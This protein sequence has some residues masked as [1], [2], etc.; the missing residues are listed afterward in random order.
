MELNGLDEEQYNLPNVPEPSV[1]V[2]PRIIFVKEYIDNS[3]LND[4]DSRISSNVSK[5]DR[6]SL[7]PSHLEESV[8][9]SSFHSTISLPSNG[10]IEVENNEQNETEE[11]HSN[12]RNFLDVVNTDNF[13][14]LVVVAICILSFLSMVLIPY[15][16]VILTPFYWYESI[17]IGVLGAIP[18]G[19]GVCVVY[20]RILLEYQD[21]TRPITLLKVF[22]L[23][24]VF[25]ALI[26]VLAHLSWSF[27]LG[28][29]SP[30]PYSLA[31]DVT[32]TSIITVA[33][34]W[35]VLPQNI[36]AKYQ[37]RYKAFIRYILL[38]VAIP[39]VVPM[40][41]E[42]VNEISAV[43]GI[44]LKWMIAVLLLFVKINSNSMMVKVLTIFAL[45][46]KLDLAKNLVTV[47]NGVIFKSI[48][49]ILIGSKTDVV[50]GYC[51]QGISMIMLMRSLNNIIHLHKPKCKCHSTIEAS[52]KR[53]QELLT[54][55]MLNETLDLF[56]TIAYVLCTTVAYYGPN[57]GIIGNIQNNYWQ[58]HIIDS[59]PEFLTTMAYSLL[60]DVSV[61]VI[62]L[63]I[64]WYYCRING[65]LFFK[66]KIGQYAH[67]LVLC[68]TREINLVSI[69][70]IARHCRII[71]LLI[72][73]HQA[74]KSYLSLITF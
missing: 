60:I 1:S 72:T 2:I 56:T 48:I 68:I 63:V 71:N 51:F 41:I 6:I 64:L 31:I 29:N 21:I 13:Q 37:D 23:F 42:S 73:H 62:T 44:N 8:S 49:L 58:Y 4:T 11:S 15:H 43:T 52:K 14:F 40:I 27:G 38:G 55:L 18:C 16:N 7:N 53:K 69:L 47:E 19:F 26:H 30:I 74:N 9:V 5:D 24:A 39:V 28:Y 12:G 34:I 25:Y 35:N 17:P 10:Q 61:G 46:Q 45:P 67:S 59:F 33:V 57:A 65:L 22:L 50:T 66:D 54:T 3:S 36:T 20:I 32:F 70:V